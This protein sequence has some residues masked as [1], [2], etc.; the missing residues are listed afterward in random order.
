MNFHF[1]GASFRHLF[2]QQLQQT[3]AQHQQLHNPQTLCATSSQQ[4]QFKTGRL[5]EEEMPSDTR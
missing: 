1:F 4:Q 5:Y 2:S 3:S